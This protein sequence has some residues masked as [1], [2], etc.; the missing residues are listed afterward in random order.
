MTDIDPRQIRDGLDVFAPNDIT[1]CPAQLQAYLEHYGLAALIPDCR[2]SIG[3][4]RIESVSLVV[5]LYRPLTRACGT[6]VVMHGYTDHAGLYAHLIEYLLAQ[7]WGVLIYDLPGHGLSGGAPL[8]IDQFAT[9]A[10]QLSALLGCHAQSLQG[11]WILLGQSTGAAILMEQ[12]RGGNCFTG[13]EKVAGRIYLAPLIRP[14]MMQ[15]IARKY[16]WFGRFLRQVKR[17][18]SDNS[19]DAA[20]VRFVR[21]HDPLQHARVAV[22]WVR[23]MLEWIKQI[24]ASGPLSGRPLV[25][26]G[27][28]DG[29]V[30]WQHNLEVLTR[31]YPSV[32]S[33]LLAKARHHLVNETPALRAE[34]FRLIGIH[35]G[36]VLHEVG[37]DGGNR[38]GE[39]RHGN[40]QEEG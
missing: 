19:G 26:Q 31:L 21:H 3:V 14:V 30:D 32:Q 12:Q 11:P 28:K 25:I 34:V 4:Q 27:E 9:Y 13:K 37:G 33:V 7:N 29:T 6:V 10:L 38:D 36:E 35:L 15:T 23:A 17:I 5:Q 8:A 1:L 20:F 22:S 39:E 40:S 18:Y 16:Y 24:E 2:Y